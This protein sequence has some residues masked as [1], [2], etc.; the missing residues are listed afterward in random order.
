M[1]CWEEWQTEQLDRRLDRV[2]RA[3]Y[4]ARNLPEKLDGKES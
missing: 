4:I 1:K 3:A 2:R